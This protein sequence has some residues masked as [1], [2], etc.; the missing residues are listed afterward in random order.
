[1]RLFKALGFAL[2]MLAASIAAAAERGSADE[3]MAMVKKAVAYMKDVGKDKAFAEF[4]NTANTQFHDRDLYIFV[5]DMHGNNVAHGNNPK[6]VGKNLLEMKD[7]DGKYIIKG[8]I[9]V[10]KAKGKGWVD[11]KWPNPV[12]KAVES[13]SS[14]VEKVDDLIVG[15]GI[16]K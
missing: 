9:D 7:N 4:G 5:Y 2:L 1:M 16:Y 11:Y 15:A 3:A 8:F 6:M 12:T 13:K 10:T 14:Y